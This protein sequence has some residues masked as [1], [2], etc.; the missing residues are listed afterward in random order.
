MCFFDSPLRQV[1][2]EMI[3]LFTCEIGPLKIEV[4]Q[5]FLLGAFAGA[6]FNDSVFLG[7]KKRY[8]SLYLIVGTSKLLIEFVKLCM[9]FGLILFETI[10]E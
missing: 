9:N 7:K 8:C 1:Y 5:L 3:L 2:W 10:S 4:A 6:L